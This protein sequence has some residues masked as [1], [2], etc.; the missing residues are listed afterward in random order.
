[1]ICL[2][3]SSQSVREQTDANCVE[4]ISFLVAMAEGVAASATPLP[5]PPPLFHIHLDPPKAIAT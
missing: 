4:R 5:P 3:Q 2:K 1:M